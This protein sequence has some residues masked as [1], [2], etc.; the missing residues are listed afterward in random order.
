[1][2]AD[3]RKIGAETARTGLVALRAG[4]SQAGIR[5]PLYGDD[6]AET[7]NR[8]ADKRCPYPLLLL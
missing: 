3:D 8:W 7:P 1:M 4:S 6:N 5:N 2:A